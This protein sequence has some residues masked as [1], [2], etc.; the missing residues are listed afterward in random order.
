M[1][2][3]EKGCVAKLQRD[4]FLLSR[5]CLRYL[6]QYRGKP[7][8]LNKMQTAKDTDGSE[9]KTWPTCFLKK[10]IRSYSLSPSPR[11]I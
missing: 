1:K 10:A 3:W 6:F 2:M 4:V 7:Y 8:L 9:E 5:R 11:G